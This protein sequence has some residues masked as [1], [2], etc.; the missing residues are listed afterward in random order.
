MEEEAPIDK[1][2][3]EADAKIMAELIQ[4]IPLFLIAIL[5]AIFAYHS[6]MIPC[7]EN[8]EVWFQRSGSIVVLLAVWIEYKLFKINGDVHPSGMSTSQLNKLT[9]KYGTSHKVA[10]Y[11]AAALAIT[12]TFIWGY[13][14]FFV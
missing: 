3:R 11:L 5:S 14:D 13:G 10:S 9:E 8:P 12:G 7:G 4:C 1:Y 2:V 6:F